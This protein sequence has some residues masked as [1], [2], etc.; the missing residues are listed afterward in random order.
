MTY[1]VF[2]LFKCV[3]LAHFQGLITILLV[4]IV[5]FD[6]NG[7]HNRGSSQVDRGGN[8]EIKFGASGWIP[9]VT[10]VCVCFL[11]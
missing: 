5:L 7:A 9:S 3:L 8:V 10:E 4:Y 11:H 2:V 1:G 6:T